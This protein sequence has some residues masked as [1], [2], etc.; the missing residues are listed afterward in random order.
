M[1]A[2]LSIILVI[3]MHTSSTAMSVFVSPNG[4]DLDPGTAQLPFATLAR[5]QQA[6]RAAGPGARV[7][8]RAGTHC[9]AE[10]LRF[11]ARDSGHTYEALTGETS[12]VSGGLRI[13]GWKQSGSVWEAPLALH[14]PIRD[15]YV[16]ARR[17]VRARAP[18]AGF[19]TGLTSTDGLTITFPPGQLHRWSN[20]DDVELATIVEWTSAHARL[21]DA[22]V[23]LKQ[24]QIRFPRLALTFF[25]MAWAGHIRT[26]AP[27][28]L[29]HFENAPELLDAPGE[30]YFD[31]AR[32]LIRYRGGKPDAIATRLEQ[33]I[34]VDGAT[35][36][37][38]RGLTFSHTDWRLPEDGFLPLQT[39][40]TVAMQ[41]E[42]LIHDV[43]APAAL[44]FVRAVR[45]RVENCRLTH[46]GATALSV[47][48]GSRDCHITGNVVEDVGGNGI[49]LGEINSTSPQPAD[50]VKDNS[51]AHNT[52]RHCGVT[53][54]GSA[55]IFVA[56]AEGTLIAHNEVSDL[57]YSGITI[58]WRWDRQPTQ[59]R[60]NRV[61]F[62]H[63]HHVA[64]LLADGGGIYTLGV[65]PESVMRGNLLHDIVRKSGLAPVNG[66][67]MD[68][69]TSGWR[70]EGNASYNV[71]EGGYRYNQTGAAF[72]Q[73]G[74]QHQPLGENF[75][76][77]QPDRLPANLVALV[78]PK[79]NMKQEK[80][81]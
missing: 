35:N 50:L 21:K 39:C 81:R 6:A 65:Q 61:E 38:F 54:R 51:I 16:N 32:N 11:D 77:L 66:L 80:M 5:A 59:A 46:L 63:V 25:D 36:L 15:L 70:I 57:P 20:P 9:L 1:I 72:G 78:G 28:Y 31:R 10:P 22:V 53:L 71:P 49:Q 17:A 67:F 24:N 48:A 14:D 73:T 64:Q 69:G 55:G 7:V 44:R 23:D 47:E 33:L 26:N 60:R 29:Y 2:P 45:C 19:H 12:V 42:A 62:N 37:T 18:N 13:T 3:L 43:S 58:G 41:N 75:F 27:N 8:L 34:V 4:N 56:L 30:W 79:L 52:V 68:N 40:V 76:D 74:P